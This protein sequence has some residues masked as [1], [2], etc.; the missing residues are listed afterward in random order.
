[1]ED[2]MGVTA[3]ISGRGGIALPSLLLL[4]L[5]SLI[6]FQT[7]LLDLPTFASA[8]E[9]PETV[10]VAPRPFAYR[11]GGDY[12]RGTASID[13]P[14][15]HVD[16]GRSLEIMR[17]QVSTADYGVCVADGSCPRAEPRRRGVGNV[18]V[19]GVSFDDAE[20]YAAWLSRRTGEVWRLPTIEE[21]A[22]A[23]GTKATDHALG[24]ETDASDPAERWLLAYAKESALNQDGPAAPMPLGTFGENE[25]GV[26]DLSA[27][28]WEW[29]STCASRTTVD[30]MDRALSHI[31]N[32][33]VR[34]LEG[35]HR[36]AMSKFVDDALGGGCSVGAPPDNLGFRLVRERPWFTGALR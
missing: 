33:G 25:F 3:T 34:Y 26:A 27:V 23:A 15:I 31:E 1:L 17:Y 11:A 19:T 30:L 5:V 10:V 4:A 12:L 6:G 20:D 32:C 9:G 2:T 13:G 7:E 36:T 35:R 29:T 16:Q 21:W 24:I 18:P 14:L 22:F 8:E 28:V